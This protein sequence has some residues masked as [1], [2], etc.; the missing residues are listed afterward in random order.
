MKNME[1]LGQLQD[2]QPGQL[3]YSTLKIKKE[4]CIL[5]YFILFLD[6]LWYNLITNKTDY[7]NVCLY[8]LQ[9][10]Q[11]FPWCQWLLLLILWRAIR[12]LW[13]VAVMLTQQLPIP[14]PRRTKHCLLKKHSLSSS[15]S[16]PL[17]LKSIAAQLRTSWGGHPNTSPL[18]WNVSI[19]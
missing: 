3:Q 14:G 15:T 11:T 17:I 5:F 13:N 16:S 4:I 19:I 6:S 18:M 8:L 7:V 2:Q 12:W 10:L 1:Y 9:M